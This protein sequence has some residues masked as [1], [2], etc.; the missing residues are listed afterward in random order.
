MKRPSSL[1]GTHVQAGRNAFRKD[2]ARVGACA[3]TGALIFSSVPVYALAESA[4]GAGSAQ[5]Q[6]D[7]PPSGGGMGQGGGADT[8]TYDYTGTLSGI[9]IADGDDIDSTGTTSSSAKDVNA[10]LVENGGTLALDAATLEKS[11]DDTDGDACNFYGVNS[12]LLAVGE[13]ST[14]TVQRSTLSATS[15]GS[16][17]IFATDGAKVLAYEDEIQTTAGNSRGLDATYGGEI[18]GSALTISTEGDHCA[19]LATDRGGGTVSVTDSELE[20]AGSGSPLLYSTGDVEVAGVTGTASG[21]Q[22]A[23]MEGLNTILIEDSTLSSTMT[24]ATASDPMADAVIIYQSTSGDAES[25]TGETAKFQAADST[26]SSAIASGSFFYLTNTTADIVLSNTILDFDSDAAAL[27]TAEGNDSNNWGSAGSNGATVRFTA[28]GETLSGAIAADTISSADVYLTDGTTWTGA[29]KI[30]TN[31]AGSTST[32]PL[33]VSVDGTSS[34]VVTDDS[35][36]SNL[37]L[38]EGASVTDGNGND[39]RIV[40]EAGNVLRAGSSD[41]TVT[42]EGNYSSAYDASNAGTLAT[43]TADRSAF[44]E[45]FGTDTSFTMGEKL[46]QAGDA[47]ESAEASASTAQDSSQTESTDVNLSWWDQIVLFFKGLFG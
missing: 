44:D 47:S 43:D 29:A 39:V 35:T 5:S 7:E 6:P 46:S 40:D 32:S 2:L 13:G 31:S 41:V 38:A 1:E 11:G 4:P 9:L 28:I 12:I 3:L 24:E 14:A 20:T 21:S 33:S 27:L 26:L 16:N 17:G 36:V 19:A 8:M 34:W 10:A 45:A 42:V 23:G 30:E 25:T 15:E 22:I 37:T 18:L